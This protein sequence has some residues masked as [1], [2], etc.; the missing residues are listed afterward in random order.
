MFQ[1]AI[2][3]KHSMCHVLKQTRGVHQRNLSP[4]VM[5]EL[6]PG[7]EEERGAEAGMGRDGQGW[8]GM[9][10]DGQREHV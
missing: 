5:S 2:S 4:E 1:Q 7:N 6:G 10:R 8:A 3:V 9:G